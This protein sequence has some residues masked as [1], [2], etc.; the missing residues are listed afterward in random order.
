M[1]SVLVYYNTLKSLCD[2]PFRVSGEAGIHLKNNILFATTD[3]V[4]DLEFHGSVTS[5]YNGYY[6]NRDGV[7]RIGKLVS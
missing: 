3:Y 1:D 7:A 4:M 2:T 6:T 5:D